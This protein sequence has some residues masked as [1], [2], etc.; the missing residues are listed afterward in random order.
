MA[1][2]NQEVKITEG[3]RFD[4]DVYISYRIPFNCVI[5]IIIF[6]FTKL[7]GFA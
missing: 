5:K 2:V 1:E 7:Y 6:V 3:E 4:I